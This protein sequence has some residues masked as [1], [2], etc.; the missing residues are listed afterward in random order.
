MAMQLKTRYLDISTIESISS[1]SDRASLDLFVQ[2]DAGESESDVRNF[3]RPLIPDS[4][5]GLIFTE[6]AVS[7][8]SDEL[9][10]IHAE[11]SPNTSPRAIVVLNVDDVRWS[12]K[13]SSGQQF[14]TKF[15]RGLVAEQTKNDL[16]ALK[17]AGTPAQNSIG[18]V[19]YTKKGWRIEGREISMG[20]VLIDVETVKSAANVSGGYLITAAQAASDQ[21]VNA[22]SWKGFAAGTLKLLSYSASEQGSADVSLNPPD[23]DVQ[24]T[25]EFQANR[26]GL[27][28]ASNIAAVD[29]LGHQLL[30]LEVHPGWDDT[31]KTNDDELQRVAVHDIWPT[32]NF[33]SVLGI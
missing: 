13:S 28:F 10:D 8:I 19:Y 15:S 27:V 25:M 14:R 16:T 26:S 32:I 21:S 24:F 12:V 29:V 3:A 31:K 11:Y 9:W 1:D 22:A 4:Y 5:D 30:E 33:S 7:R 17:L 2:T 20:T 18:R 23:W 6:M